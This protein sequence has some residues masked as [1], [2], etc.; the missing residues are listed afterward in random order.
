MLLRRLH[1]IVPLNSD[2]NFLS[3]YFGGETL[4]Q[5]SCRAKNAL[6]T[7]PIGDC[8]SFSNF[9]SD[10]L[11]LFCSAFLHC[12]ISPKNK[13]GRWKQNKERNNSI[14]F[15]FACRMNKPL[16]TRNSLCSN[17]QVLVYES[18][19]VEIHKLSSLFS[20]A[21]GDELDTFASFLDRVIWKHI[22]PTHK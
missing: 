17:L 7:R 9:L 19:A 10:S 20:S 16:L 5:W 11:S 21:S 3:K 15:Y 4:W 2:N 6:E 18:G 8:R 14:A 13:W 22:N 12:P 1:L